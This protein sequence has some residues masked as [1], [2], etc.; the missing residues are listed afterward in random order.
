M[1]YDKWNCVWIKDVNTVLI[2]VVFNLICWLAFWIYL[3]NSPFCYCVVFEF[4]NLKLWTKVLVVGRRLGST[5]TY[6]IL[7]VLIW[8]GTTSITGAAFRSSLS[9]CN[10]SGHPPP[11]CEPLF[12]FHQH[13]VA[14][15]ASRLRPRCS[16]QSSL[17]LDVVSLS[18]CNVHHRCCH[19]VASA[20]AVSPPLVHCTSFSYTSI[21]SM[22]ISYTT[23]S[24]TSFPVFPCCGF[25]KVNFQR[26]FLWFSVLC[27]EFTKRVGIASSSIF[28]CILCYQVP[29]SN[30]FLWCQ[31][32]VCFIYVINYLLKYI[33]C[34]SYMRVSLS[35]P[36]EI[37]YENY[38]LSQSFHFEE[39]IF[40]KLD[41]RG[42]NTNNLN[43]L[44]LELS[45]WIV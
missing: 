14:T 12:L 8:W 17:R 26:V 18:L 1:A 24:R 2:T 29:I 25:S 10:S 45:D 39:T 13:Y 16:G 23:I 31:Y 19:H 34:F 36:F 5:V 35:F 38:V 30:I 28:I 37:Q 11:P 33:V 3:P 21:S 20:T 43:V 44:N 42:Y 32:V 15:V 4:G 40:F 7:S 27:L 6:C 22:T 41:I 9:L